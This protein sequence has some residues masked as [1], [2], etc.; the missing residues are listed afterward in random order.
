MSGPGKKRRGPKTPPAQAVS[1]EEMAAILER[2]RAV[3]SPEEHAKLTGAIDTLAQVTAQLQAKDASIERLRRMIFGATTET[4][5]NVLGTDTQT[6]PASTPPNTTPGPKVRGHGRNAA[7]AYTGAQQVAVMRTV[8]RGVQRRH[9]HEGVAV[10]QGP[11]VPQP[12]P[13]M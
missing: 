5:R 11:N 12:S 1:R 3:L 8:A 4:S 7:A 10:N 2:T 9:H 13:M 6:A